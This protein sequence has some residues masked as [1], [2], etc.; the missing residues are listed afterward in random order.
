M[1]G[2]AAPLP[3]VL[4]PPERPHTAVATAPHVGYRDTPSCCAEAGAWRYSHIYELTSR[5]FPDLPEQARAICLQHIGTDSALFAREWQDY[6][7]A[8]QLDQSLI[9]TLEDQA[10]WMLGKETGDTRGVPNFLDFIHSDG[11]KAVEPQ[12]VTIAGQ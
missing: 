2:S 8:V 10:R 5:H 9:L 11:L 12:A 3:P 1:S 7:F 6:H 4:A